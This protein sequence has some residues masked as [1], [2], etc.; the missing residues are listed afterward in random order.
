MSYHGI[1]NIY[2]RDAPKEMRM[3]QL[4]IR[5]KNV[6]LAKRSPAYIIFAKQ[7]VFLNALALDVAAP[8]RPVYVTGTTMFICYLNL[9]QNTNI[10]HMYLVL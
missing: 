9:R 1:T 10:V 4:N 2:T 6:K 3:V 5:I 8:S 7:K